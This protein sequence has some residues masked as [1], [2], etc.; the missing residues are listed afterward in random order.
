MVM[1]DAEVTNETNKRIDEEIANEPTS[2]EIEDDLLTKPKETEESGLLVCND[3]E[4]KRRSGRIK[5][6]FYMNEFLKHNFDN[7]LIKGV[8]KKWDGVGVI[9]GMEGSGKSTASFGYAKYVDSTFPGELLPGE[10]TLRE[11]TRIVFS[12]NEL[13]KC[14]DDSKPG[15]AIVFDEAV[16]GFLAG[17]AGTE[18]QKTLIK[19]MVTIRKKRLYIFIVIPSIFLLRKYMAIFRARYLIHFYSPDGISR[20]RFKFY[21]YDTK[22]KLYIKGLKEFD[23]DCVK[24]DFIGNAVDLEGFFFD[25]DTYEKKKDEAI[26]KITEA[27]QK[28]KEKKTVS[29]F[30]KNGIAYT[31]FKIYEAK[32]GYS[33]PEFVKKVLNERYC[34]DLDPKTFRN[35]LDAFKEQKL[36]MEKEALRIAEASKL[37]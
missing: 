26:K 24:A 9:T 8:K 27:P 5:K 3:I 33:L 19:K 29:D 17:D 32:Y 7:Y 23:Q 18:I 30:Y 21:S 35:Y 13:I 2:D 14:I 20:G 10:T 22:R 36:E 28:K 16:M 25:V 1:V 4:F 37:D 6:G 11:C 31:F 12:T 15:Q 34:L